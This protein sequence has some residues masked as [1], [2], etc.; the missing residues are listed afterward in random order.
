MEVS[1]TSM[2]VASITAIATGQGLVA[3]E[4]ARFCA[5]SAIL[6]SQPDCFPKKGKLQDAW[7]GYEVREI[8]RS[9][10]NQDV[11]HITL[12]RANIEL[13]V[14]AMDSW[15]RELIWRGIR[16]RPRGWRWRS[17]LFGRRT[18]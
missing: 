3:V 12:W 18:P 17:A 2:K 5:A 1:R 8:F 16:C 11:S 10:G 7:E 6:P 13:H 4:A 15:N 14:L 9:A